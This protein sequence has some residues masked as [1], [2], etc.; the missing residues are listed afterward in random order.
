LVVARCR[1]PIRQTIV[2]SEAKRVSSITLH[3]DGAEAV[4]A[5]LIPDTFS[6]TGLVVAL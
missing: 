4:V 2:G 1:V 3:V 5:P 6:H